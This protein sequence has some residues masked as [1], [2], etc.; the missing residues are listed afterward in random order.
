MSLWCH[1]SH[2]NPV[3]THPERIAREDK[4]LVNNLDYDRVELPV[5]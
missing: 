3:K 4:K 1:V 5:R 2:V